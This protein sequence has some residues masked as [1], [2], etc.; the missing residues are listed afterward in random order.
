MARVVANIGAHKTASSLIQH[1]FKWSREHYE[2]NG[3]ALLLRDEAGQC[4]GRGGRLISDPELLRDAIQDRLDATGN[5]IAFFSYEDTLG[6][7]FESNAGLYAGK[8]DAISALHAAMRG[9][10]ARILYLIRPQWEFVESYYLQK[11]NEG[12]FLTFHQFMDSIEIGNLSWRP[13]VETLR[14][15]FGDDN[16]RIGDFRTIRNGQQEFMEALVKENLSSDLKLAPVDVK[17]HNASLSDRGLQI[18]LRINPLLKPG[19]EEVG[20]VRKFLQ[21]NFS[22]RTEPRPNLIGI[23]LRDRLVD[24]YGKEYEELVR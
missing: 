11:V 3:L 15:E 19:W 8:S 1:H 17:V 14:K 9:F 5:D 20:K 6:K 16:V 23:D 2:K 18:A 12:Y 10:D 7:P 21:N 4:I 24:L 13:L 22:N